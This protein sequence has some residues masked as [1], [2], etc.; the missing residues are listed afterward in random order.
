[1]VF[2]SVAVGIEVNLAFHHAGNVKLSDMSEEDLQSLVKILT[3]YGHGLL[4]TVEAS[5]HSTTPPSKEFVA[6]AEIAGVRVFDQT[7]PN[8]K[9]ILLQKYVQT[10]SDI[11]E[12]PLSMVSIG[13][14]AKVLTEQ[15]S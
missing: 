3:R 15:V 10:R 9:A 7:H 11:E 6:A 14:L 13:L 1:M 4:A 2:S 8:T 12:I 5:V